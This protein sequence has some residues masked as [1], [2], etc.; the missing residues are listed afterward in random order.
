MAG[1]YIHI[2]F[3][4][5]R[6]IYCDFYSNTD[7][8]LKQAYVNAL[9]AEIN[10]RKDEF[11]KEPVST[12][13]FG[14][15]TPSQLEE[16]DFNRIFSAV[17]LLSSPSDWKEVTIEANPDDLS[18]DYIAMLR[19]LPF[20]RISI[21]VQSFNDSDL[22]FLNRRHTA[23][24]AIEAIER[25]RAAGLENISIDLMY[26]LPGQSSGQWNEN[27]VQALTLKPQHLSCYHLIYEK[28]TALYN[29]LQKKQIDEID[30]ETS[31]AMFS[32]LMERLHDA[33][34]EHYEISNFALPGYRSRHNSSYWQ[35]KPYIGIGTSAHS[36]N[37][38]SRQWNVADIREYI[39]QNKVGRFEPE[40]EPIDCD[41]RYNESVITALR[42]CEGLEIQQLE[43]RFGK[44][45]KEYCLRMSEPFISSEKMILENGRLR[46]SKSG[47]FVSD[48]I[49]SALLFVSDAE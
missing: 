9:I 34:Y 48:A 13:Y 8:G 15:G 28:G 43:Q 45:R 24:Q 42:T 1:L 14:G 12:L 7:M 6:C 23:R 27:L 38:G 5:R 41:T 17:S 36:Y 30:E 3:C 35:D 20:N 44:E 37:G 40:V 39:A 25:C 46:L 29:L 4:K 33:G 22:L 26:G 16:D 18:P 31:V 49:M 19:S 10:A 47:I 32:L 21:G 2:P 11:L